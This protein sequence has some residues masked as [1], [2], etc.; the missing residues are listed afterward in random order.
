MTAVPFKYEF[1]QRLNSG[2]DVKAR[3]NGAVAIIV[4]L[5]ARSE[6][7][8]MFATPLFLPVTSGSVSFSTA[9]DGRGAPIPRG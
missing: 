4:F 2:D 5:G 7:S 1:F 6:I 3:I 8:S 9:A